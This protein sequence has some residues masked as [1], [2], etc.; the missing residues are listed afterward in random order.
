MWNYARRYYV[1]QIGADNNMQHMFRAVTDPKKFLDWI[2]PR[3]ASYIGIT[4]LGA[5]SINNT[6]S[7]NNSNNE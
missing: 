5:S 7:N 2:N 4:G 6:N 3:V 1:K